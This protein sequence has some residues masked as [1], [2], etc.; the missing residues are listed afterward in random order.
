MIYIYIVKCVDSTFYT[1]ITQDLTVR[2]QQH[3]N[4]KVSYTRKRLPIQ[5]IHTVS[6][7]TRK[8]AAKLER[9]IKNMGAK[10][11]LIRNFANT[12]NNFLHL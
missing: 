2:M 11:Y 1:G 8:E 9:H 7:S 6:R 5:I 3:N 12:N 10:K 4:R